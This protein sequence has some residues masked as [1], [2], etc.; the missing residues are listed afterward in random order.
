VWLRFFEGRELRIPEGK[1]GCSLKGLAFIWGGGEGGR[2]HSG[3]G[4]GRGFASVK[5]GR[6]RVTWGGDGGG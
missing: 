2:V 6:F 1:G 4:K 5:G 3:R